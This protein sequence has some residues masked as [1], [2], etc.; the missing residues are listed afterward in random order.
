MN[1]EVLKEHYRLERQFLKLEAARKTV[2]DEARD[3]RSGSKLRA[4]K[5]AELDAFTTQIDPLKTRWKELCSQFDAG[6]QRVQRELN[7]VALKLS[8]EE[9]AA[10]VAVLS[11]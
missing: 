3:A 10:L 7:N 9:Q 1:L 5:D 6:D 4:D 2:A 11:Q 8:A